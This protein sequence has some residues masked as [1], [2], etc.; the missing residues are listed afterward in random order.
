MNKH[1]K[2]LRKITKLLRGLTIQDVI[3]AATYKRIEINLSPAAIK[4]EHTPYWKE[5]LDRHNATDT[6][7]NK[8]DSLN[9]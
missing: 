3:T 6:K 7:K 8:F 9:I 4:L 2:R 1:K 5:H